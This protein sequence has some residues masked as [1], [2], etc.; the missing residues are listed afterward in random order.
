MTRHRFVCLV[1]LSMLAVGAADL[2]AQSPEPAALRQLN[3]V[4]VKVIV[5]VTARSPKQGGPVVE[6]WVSEQIQQLGETEYFA[7]TGWVPVCDALLEH[8]AVD[9]RVWDGGLSGRNVFCPAGGDIPER[10]NGR[11]L[12]SVAGWLPFYGCEAR[13]SLLDEPGSRAVG[14]VQIFSGDGVERKPVLTKHQL[15]YVAVIIAPPPHE[16]FASRGEAE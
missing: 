12:V 11:V 14:P 5:P 2:P 1:V 6:S 9:N 3:Q 15:P 16:G 8:D 13:V 7:V 10:E 4:F